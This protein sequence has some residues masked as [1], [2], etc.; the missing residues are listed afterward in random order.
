MLISDWINPHHHSLNDTR[1]AVVWLILAAFLWSIGGLLIK[2]V[3]WN[4]VAIAGTRSLIAAATLWVLIPRTE[5]R[6]GPAQ[7][8]GAVVYAATVISFVIAN[9][10]TT[11]ANAIFLQYTAPIYI[12]IFGAWF[13]GEKTSRMDWLL[14][15]IAQAGTALFFLDQ[16]E[17][18]GLWGNLCALGSGVCFATLAMHLRRHREASP[19]AAV[20]LGN[21]L[22]FVIGIP[23]MFESHPDA[24]GWMGLLLLGVFQLGLSYKLYTHAIRHIR[25]LEASLIGTLEPVLNPVWVFLAVGEKPGPWALAG[26][27]IVIASVT[28]RAVLTARSSKQSQANQANN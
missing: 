2:L 14:L 27:A 15:G 1:K 23:F 11:A 24:R 5:W 22:T 17:G 12:A 8:F 28:A 25:A 20:F 13:L 10:L 16:F 19:A 9:K 6:F 4:P 7:W 3:Q 21:I 18:R 26:G